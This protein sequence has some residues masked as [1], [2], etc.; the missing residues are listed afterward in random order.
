MTK[1][2]QKV[3]IKKASINDSEDLFSL[4]D[5]LADYEK[6]ER[7]DSDA[8][9]R[10]LKDAFGKNPKI[11]P[12]LAEKDGKAAA[13]AIT[14]Y[15]YSSFLALPTL[16]LKD[17]FVLPEYRACGI[18]K[19]LFRHLVKLAYD[20]GCGRMEWQVLDWNQLAINFYEKIGAKHMK[21]WFTYRLDRELLKKLIKDII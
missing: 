18:G 15:T 13:Y 14:L 11:T 1:I 10:F 7:P 12:W 9:K 3:N 6:L 21:E 16:Y 19:S 17:V 5:A 2:I 4:I 8:K 20:E